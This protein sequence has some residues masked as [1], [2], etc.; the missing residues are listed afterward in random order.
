MEGDLHSHSGACPALTKEGMAEE[1]EDQ[2][3]SSVHLMTNLGLIVLQRDWSCGFRV[4]DQRVKGH[5]HPITS[6]VR[7]IKMIYDS[8]R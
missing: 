4:E 7:I 3:L 1:G 6:K 8:C 2:G 5:P